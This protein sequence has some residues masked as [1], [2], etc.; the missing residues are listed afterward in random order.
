MKLNRKIKYN[1]KVCR[2]Q[3]FGSY[4]KG[5]GHS[6]VWGQIHHVSALIMKLMKQIW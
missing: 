2:V 6:R 3:D 5:Q 4:A 1:K